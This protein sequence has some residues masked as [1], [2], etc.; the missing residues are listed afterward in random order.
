M[1][2]VIQQVY[3]TL[4]PVLLSALSVFIAFVTLQPLALWLDPS[5]NL[6]ASRG[7]GKVAFVTMI[8]FQ[9]LLFMITQ[10]LPFLDKCLKTSL[11]FFKK[12]IWIKT[13]FFYFSIFFILHAFLLTIFFVFGYAQYNP[14][15]GTFNIQLILK[16]I[17]GFFVVFMLAWTEEAIFRGVIYQYIEQRFSK[18]ISIF[19]AS[20]IFM[21]THDLTNPLNLTTTDWKLGLG[22]F[23]LG[24]LLNTIFV[25]T[26]KLYAGM[27]LHAGIVFVKVVLRRARFIIIPISGLPF[28]INPDLRQSLLVH[29]LFAILIVALII[30]NRKRLL[31]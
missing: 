10:S 3:R 22:L 31:N 25:I 23:L 18:I 9:L 7:I 5:F 1:R 17:W 8:M 20:L 30:F 27:G 13:F 4:G 29:F 2:V 6:L 21:L 16:L 24:F 11:F 26:G 28:W 12:P 15:W 19:T 14:G